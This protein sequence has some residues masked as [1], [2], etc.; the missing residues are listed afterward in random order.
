MKSTTTT[1]KTII[2]ARVLV[3][4]IILVSGC[5]TA[6]APP[7]AHLQPALG[8]TV[9]EMPQVLRTRIERSASYTLGD[10]TSTSTSSSRSP[11]AFGWT[12]ANAEARRGSPPQQRKGD[13]SKLFATPE[14][15]PVQGRPFVGLS[16]SFTAL[17]EG[18]CGSSPIF[19]G[20]V[21]LVYAFVPLFAVQSLVAWGV[22]RVMYWWSMR[23]AD[24]SRRLPAGF[25]GYMLL[26]FVVGG[27]SFMNGLKAVAVLNVV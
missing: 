9:R 19:F 22:G 11:A 16:R 12:G 8:N 23:G 3:L 25:V 5:V 20:M 6:F 24:V 18:S 14:P 13:W 27:L 7:P 26:F 4:S 10:S 1:T 15:E 21:G 17:A 2:S